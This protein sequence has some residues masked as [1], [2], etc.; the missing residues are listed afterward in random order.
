M[1]EACIQLVG[2]S[3]LAEAL[4]SGRD[5]HLALAAT[6]L[7]I[8][9]EEALVRKD[10]GDKKVDD[11]R[12]TSKVANFGFAGG[13]GAEK[14]V[15]FARKAYKVRLS[16]DQAKQLKRDWLITWPE[17][18]EYFK[19]HAALS[20]AAGAAGI[21]YKQLFSNRVRGG[22]SYSAACNGRFQGLGADATGNAA[23]LISEAC[24]VLPESPLFGAR[25]VRYVHDDFH[26]ETT[27]ARGHDVAHELVR[28]M[29]VGA[30]PYLPHV[31]ATAE[32]LLSRYW[33]KEAFALFDAAGRL[34]PW[35]AELGAIVHALPKGKHAACAEGVDS[36]PRAVGA[37]LVQL[38]TR[39]PKAKFKL[40]GNAIEI[41]Q[42]DQATQRIAA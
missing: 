31:P 7:G 37:K 40:D 13:L 29:I 6:I 28:L 11:A 27:I 26:L 5:V 36:Y 2:F 3:R 39:Y 25:L 8:S 42:K 9:Y 4:N 23:F 38:A 30:A 21:T 18:V 14:F 41:L 22:M 34:Y 32:P 12:Q 15:L 17:F 33:S 20:K 16:V 35:D 10:A 24:Y 19:I 1:A